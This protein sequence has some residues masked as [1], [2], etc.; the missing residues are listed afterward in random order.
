MLGA[1]P[2]QLKQT[3]ISIDNH[4]EPLKMLL[5]IRH[6][7]S[8]TEELNLPE[9]SPA[10]EIGK[11]AL[12]DTENKH[13]WDHRWAQEWSR[14]WEWYDTRESQRAPIPP[15]E[16]IR[17]SRPGQPLHPV[18][19]PFWMTEYGPVGF[20]REAFMNWDRLTMALKPN[21]YP[22][23]P[24]LDAWQSG[25]RNITVLPYFGYFAEHRTATHLVASEN[26]MKDHAQF[27]NALG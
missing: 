6:A 26:T 19:P 17:I 18:V 11:S 3:Q 22:K 14:A 5:F 16:M 10:P 9:L 13:V 12:P 20:D 1:G 8:L 24:L 2:K 25:I 21:P 4:A 15:E 7:W 27:L 23:L